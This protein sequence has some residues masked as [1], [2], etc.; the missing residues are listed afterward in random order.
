MTFYAC[1]V[2]RSL[3]RPSRSGTALT[4]SFKEEIDQNIL[5]EAKKLYKFRN[6]IAHGQR[7][8][9]PSNYTPEEAKEAV[10]KFLQAFPLISVSNPNDPLV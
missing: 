8:Q 2:L 3:T 5:S 6:W 4:L 9:K 10:E 1:S 7:T